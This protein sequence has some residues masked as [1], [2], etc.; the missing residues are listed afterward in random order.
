M[1]KEILLSSENF[2]KSVTGISVS[3]RAFSRRLFS[4]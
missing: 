3:L 1:A 2:I 4:T